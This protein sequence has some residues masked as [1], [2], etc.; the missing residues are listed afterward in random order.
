MWLV[1]RPRATTRRWPPRTTP[2][3]PTRFGWPNCGLTRRRRSRPRRRQPVR[4]AAPTGSRPRC[5]RGPAWSSRWRPRSSTLS[6]SEIGAGLGGAMGGFGGVG[7]MGALRALAEGPEDRRRVRRGRFGS[8]WARW[9]RP[10]M[11]MMRQMGGVMFGG[12]VGQA[13]G[14]L[15]REV[16]S[17]TDVGLPL[18][19]VGHAALLPS[20]ITAFGEGLGIDARRDTIVHCAA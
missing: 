9:P 14:S 13:L 5:R 2:P 20:G 12:Q 8:P 17:S 18:A 16:V 11:S 19:G 7:A 3:L 6:A 15:S 4:G 10:L 1:R